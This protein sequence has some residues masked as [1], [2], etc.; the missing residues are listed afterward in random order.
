MEKKRPRLTLEQKELIESTYQEIG[1]S[2]AANIVNGNKTIKWAWDLIGSIGIYEQWMIERWITKYKFE[3]RG[4]VYNM[5]NS[6][7]KRGPRSNPNGLIKRKQDIVEALKI[8]KLGLDPLEYL[9][10]KNN[11]KTD[12]RSTQPG[13]SSDQGSG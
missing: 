13:R 10:Q 9:Q 8:M 4:Y 3:K 2:I 12:G 7:R 11:P 6:K 5:K 1:E